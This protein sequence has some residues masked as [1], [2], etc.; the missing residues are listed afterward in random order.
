M[1]KDATI[2]IRRVGQLNI[3]KL[4][5]IGKSPTVDIL[6][7]I[8]KSYGFQG[9]AILEGLSTDALQGG[10]QIQLVVVS[11]TIVGAIE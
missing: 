10:G 2:D 9:G 1:R 7:T 4:P 3:G 6:Q 5:T 11:V 8:V